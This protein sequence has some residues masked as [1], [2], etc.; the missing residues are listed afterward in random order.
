MTQLPAITERGEYE[1]LVIRTD[2]GDETAW[3]AVVT[4]LG[5]P[6]G[7]EGEFPSEVH[8]VDDPAWAGGTPAEVLTAP[9]R[10]E[11]LSVV[12]L[13]HHATMRSA[14]R[15]LLALD[16]FAD[17]DEDLDPVYHQELIDPPRPREFRT[18]PAGVHEVHANMRLANVDVEDFVQ[19]AS[20]HADQVFRPPSGA[21]GTQ[22]APDADPHVERTLDAPNA[23]G[24]AR[25]L[26]FRS[27]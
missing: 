26:D 13:A 18:V 4:E 6:W 7:D 1:A 24:A 2:Y 19:A 11:E 17:D 10:D 3:R 16:L 20:A 8:I 25:R 9:R 12:F 22:R 14:P 27:A 23:P 15:A 5:Q 21:N